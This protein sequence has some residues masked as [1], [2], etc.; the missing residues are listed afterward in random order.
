MSSSAL[1]LAWEPPGPI[2]AAYMASS[3]DVQLLNG[4]IGSGKTTTV[5]MKAIRVAVRQR[6]STITTDAAGRGGV[7][8][9]RLC[10]VRDT[11]RQLWKTT[12]PSWF[13]RVP[14]AVG[15]FVG[16][17]GAPA[18]H[19][20]GFTLSDGSSVDFQV[21]FVAIGENSVED[22]LRGYEVTAFYLNEAD[23]LAREVLNYARGR[24]G[25]FP[26]MS[27]G[28]PTWHGVLLDC[29]A[30]EFSSWI[31]QDI[32][33]KT[34][35]ELAAIGFA[36]FVQPS[37]LAP[38]AENLGNLPPGYYTRQ[39]AG[40]PEWYIERM[41]KN[42]PGYSR[43]GKPVYPEFS[44]KIHVA[45]ATLLPMPG[46]PLVIGLDAGMS[47]AAAFGQRMPNGQ[48]RITGEL[49][50]EPGTGAMRFADMLV[51]YL[52][53][54]W[55]NWSAITA[56]ADPSAAYGADT[57]AGE[58]TWIDIVARR[59]GIRVSAAPTNA[60]IPRWEAVRLPMTRMID[61]APGFLLS[62]ACK[63]LRE[64][65][66]SGYRF[67]RLAAGEERYAEEAEKNAYS[68][69]HDALQYLLSGG[70]EDVEIRAR[71]GE[72]RNRRINLPR[73]TPAWDPYSYTGAN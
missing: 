65:A 49:V 40:Q 15:E 62:P 35:E 61:G 8:K 50:G 10:V 19:K 68:H 2:A 28:G 22:I 29:N 33:T 4:P 48:W 30:P 13:K 27:E 55:P 17:D 9:F 38:D 32:F 39:M 20:I 47:P 63:L 34:P 36:L 43:A 59:A 18:T 57:V 51:A 3:A 21:D 73:A 53:E 64:G 69:P 37:G 72:D 60:S 46:L 41:I 42:A 16:S 11:Y 14:K 5:L 52:R 7:R 67:R 25:R 45:P 70:G 66:N 56:W 54:N 6:V 71:V 31:Y 58:A 12:I 44:D 1:T 24:T 26:E 23:L